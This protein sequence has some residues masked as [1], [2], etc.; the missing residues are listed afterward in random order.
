MRGRQ[1]ATS[2]DVDGEV[3]MSQE[4]CTKDWEKDV[5]DEEEPRI[6]SVEDAK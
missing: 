4:I 3:V 5:G 6:C 2:L 1:Q